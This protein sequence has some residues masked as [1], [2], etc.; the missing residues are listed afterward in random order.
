MQK[1][2]KAGS[3]APDNLR[4]QSLHPKITSA[5]V[6]QVTLE[7]LITYWQLADDALRAAALAVLRGER[8]AGFT[9]L[10][11]T[12]SITGVARIAGVSRQTVHAALRAGALQASPLYSGGRRRVREADLRRWLEGRAA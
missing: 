9:A 10:G 12:Y 4:P 11:K 8:S 1:L 5:S 7:I 2:V 3:G 6:V